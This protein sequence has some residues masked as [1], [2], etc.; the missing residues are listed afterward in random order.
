MKE[1]LQ[2]VSDMLMLRTD[3]SYEFRKVGTAF[4]YMKE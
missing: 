2:A 3:M 1:E 4:P